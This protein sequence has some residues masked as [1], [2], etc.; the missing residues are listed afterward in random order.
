MPYRISAFVLA[1]LANSFAV[2]IELGTQGPA[3]AAECLEKL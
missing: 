3:S 1:V 2:A